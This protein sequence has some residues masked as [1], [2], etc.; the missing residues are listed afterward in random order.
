ML[1]ESTLARKRG[2][3]ATGR[4][5]INMAINRLQSTTEDIQLMLA[6]MELFLYYDSQKPADGAAIRDVFNNLF[7]HIPKAVSIAQTNDCMLEL[8][9]FYA[10]R[11]GPEIYPVKLDFLDHLLRACKRVSDMENEFWVRKEISDIHYQQGRSDT[12][13]NQLLQIAKEQQTRGSTRICFT[14]DLLSGLYFSDANYAKALYYSLETIKNVRTGLDSLYLTNFYQRVASSYTFTGSVGEAVQWNVKHLDY[15]IAAKKTDEIFDI[16]YSITSDL[17]RLGR[18]KEALDV[19][20]EN[21]RRYPASSNYQ[22]KFM[23][24]CLAHCYASNNQNAQAE[25]YCEELIRIDALR[26]KEKEARADYSL[27]QFLVIF[28]LND[29]QFAKAEKYFKLVMEE[30]LMKANSTG[31]VFQYT[32]LFKLDSA[33][34]DYVSAI[35]HLRAA[36]RLLDSTSTST[37]SRQIEELKIAY[38]TEQKDKDIQLLTRQDELQKSKLRQGAILRNVTLAV[39]A[40]LIII[41]G[42][43]YSRFRLK[44]Q[45]NKQLQLQQREI[46]AQNLSL[47]HLV[48]EKDWLVK[49]IHHRVKNNLQIVMSLLNSQSAYTD[50]EA[51]LAAIHESQHR[52]HAM[53]LIHQK[54]YTT[55]NISTIDMSVYIREMVSY[56]RDSF[57]TGQRIHFDLNIEPT[58]MDVSQAVPIGLILNEAITNSLKYAFPGGR[59]GLIFISLSHTD[60]THRVL[61]VSDDGIGISPQLGSKKGSLGMSLMNGLSEDLEGS[62]SIE[63]VNGTTVKISF[64]QS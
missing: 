63:S 59:A 36:Q 12:A 28:Y 3:T 27:Y 11:L 35:G 13:I 47:H 50:S 54:L 61:M 37:K 62:F 57:D 25:K 21:S 45:T 22:K 53:S 8:L 2:D 56:L 30:P 34:G 10:R 58:E 24:L 55:E 20:L 42:L 14:Y 4:R 17:I 15:L 33:K 52:V 1:N 43:L 6:Y 9:D 64:G 18:N 7:E 51:A 49:E 48:N 5:L 29:K 41:L 16:I 31:T 40:L 46:A 23:N 39:A 44:Q 32:V 60:A 26:R 38:N 19:I